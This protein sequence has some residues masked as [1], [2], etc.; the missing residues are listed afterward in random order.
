MTEIQSF[1]ESATIESLVQYEETAYDKHMPVEGGKD[2]H[3][4]KIQGGK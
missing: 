3:M 4:I 1:L 2:L